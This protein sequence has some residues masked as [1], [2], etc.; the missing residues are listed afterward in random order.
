MTDSSLK[1]NLVAHLKK[2]ATQNPEKYAVIS[3][4]GNFAP[5]TFKSLF[6]EV[7]K[8]AYFF[9]KKGI[10]KGDRI[11]LIVK[12]GIDLINC[13]FGLL[14]RGAIPIII[15]PGMGLKALSKCIKTSKPVAIVG[16]P[17]A[18]SIS[19]LFS[20]SFQ[21]I[22]IRI[23][24]S[25]A[26][27]YLRDRN[28]TN[29]KDFDHVILQECDLA[30]IV[31]TSG[32]TGSPKGVRYLIKNFNTQILSLKNNFGL[33]P[34]DIDLVTLPVF[35]LFNPALS[36]TSVISDINPRKPASADPKSIVSTIIDYK[37]TTAFCSPIIGKKI[38]SYCDKNSIVL[39]NVNRIMLAGASTHPSIV[40]RLAKT[41]PNGR[42]LLPYGATEALPVSFSDHNQIKKIK[43]S[44][45]S[46]QGSSLGYPISKK[47][48]MLVPIT[49]SPLPND[50]E[51]TINPVKE[52]NCIGEICITGDIVT[53]GYDGMPGATRDAR[54][55]YNDHTYHR[56]GDIGYWDGC[57][58]LR[59]LGR[60]AE[61]LITSAG[62]LETERCEPII[63]NYDEVEKCALIGIGM[64]KIKEPCIV[65]ELVH[66]LKSYPS[67][68]ISKIRNLLNRDFTEYKIN[69]VFI[70]K[71]IPV[72]SRHNAKIHRLSLAKKWTKRVQKNYNLG[73]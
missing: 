5:K 46:G 8:T 56:M 53:D 55:H 37:I 27:E 43:D 63:N 45:L 68:L 33:G 61:L 57:N 50:W 36:I 48:V 67:A 9:K 47:S 59:F 39:P 60:K 73:L 28:E 10:K 32:S 69:R 13:C 24:V 51:E 16:I 3:T 21:S 31:F 42:V 62:M 35:S 58:S 72:D 22:K 41:I 4:E 17:L 12:P 52:Q 6:D 14:H 66:N 7:K 71:K 25:K 34:T 20:K 18:L 11:L 40:E 70:E 54:F 49:N 29:F 26:N 2:S 30:A 19:Y 1:G 23:S 64:Y 38:S 15:D 65:I 44:I